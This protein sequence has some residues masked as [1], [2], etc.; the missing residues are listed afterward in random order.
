LADAERRGRMAA[1]IGDQETADVANRFTA[2]HAE[3]VQLLERK[4]A[5]QRDELAMAERE[6]ESM[7]EEFQ[8]R[9]GA[10]PPPAGTGPDVDDAALR[11]QLDR[12]AR[13]SAADEQL[14]F[15]KRKVRGEG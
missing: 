13:E 14:A 9:R 15:L 7:R 3:R 4:V 8:Q 6:Y 11:Y 5:V 12:A 10:V 1:E 2:R